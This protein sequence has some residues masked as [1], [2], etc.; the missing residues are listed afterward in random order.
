MHIFIAGAT[1]V[2]GRAVIPPLVE[3][4]HQVT[5]LARTPEKLVLVDKMGGAPVRGDI[6]DADGMYR[7]LLERRPDAVVNLATMIPR[8]MQIDP[9]DWKLNDRIR[10]EGTRNLLRACEAAGV[11]LLVQESVGYV[12]SSQG[13]DWMTEEAPRTKHPFLKATAS[14]EDAVRSA[15]VPGVLMRLGALMSPDAWHTRE[16]V[17][18]LRRGM[19]PIIGDGSAY[20]SLIHAED[21]AAAIVKVLDHPNTAAGNTYNVVDDSPAP[22]AEVFPYAARIL[23][24]PKPKTVPPWMA[25]I[26]AGSLT[27]DILAASY[28]MQNTKLRAELGFAPKY[29]SYRETW[30]QIAR[31]LTP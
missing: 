15:R 12:C 19:L 26:V 21:A 18:A 30:S 22:M 23:S 20:L 16:S 14:M 5:G 29:P 27:L 13:A 10:S 1:G 3:A 24:A 6:L 2:L 9:D 7:L 11:A 25:K 4:G 31:A 28:R 17:S 8:R